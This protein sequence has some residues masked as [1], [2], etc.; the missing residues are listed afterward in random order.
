MKAVPAKGSSSVDIHS[1][2]ASHAGN[3]KAHTVGVE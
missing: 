2:G 3:R 1:D